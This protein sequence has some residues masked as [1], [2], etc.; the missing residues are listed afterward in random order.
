M[1][2]DGT[3]PYPLNFISQAALQPANEPLWNALVDARN[4]LVELRNVPSSCLILPQILRNK[5]S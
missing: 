1:S 2:N 4:Q 3:V 5:L